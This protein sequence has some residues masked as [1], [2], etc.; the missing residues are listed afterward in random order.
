M[1]LFCIDNYKRGGMLFLIH[2]V[3]KY[4]VGI[5]GSDFPVGVSVCRR[6]PTLIIALAELAQQLVV[7]AHAV[8]AIDFLRVDVQDVIEGAVAYHQ[9][10]ADHRSVIGR[11]C[12]V[13][14]SLNGSAV[15]EADGIY[16][17]QF[18]HLAAERLTLGL[19]EAGY[20]LCPEDVLDVVA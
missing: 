6:Y 2:H 10:L 18:K 15:T 16:L 11:S 14:Q 13:L 12:L 7:D 9:L 1:E 17:R 20:I 4:H 8:V 3:Q 5:D 19:I